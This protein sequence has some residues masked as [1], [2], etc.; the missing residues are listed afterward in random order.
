M[1]LFSKKGHKGIKIHAVP[2]LSSEEID[3]QG[4]NAESRQF[5]NL[6]TKSTASNRGSTELDLMQELQ[7]FIPYTQKAVILKLLALDD[8]EDG[9]GNGKLDSQ[10]IESN[11]DNIVQKI[12]D[13]MINSYANLG[14]LSAL[15][16]ITTY[17]SV[18]SPLSPSEVDF[19]VH[20]FTTYGIRACSV[21]NMASTCCALVTICL[22][23][24]YIYIVSNL[25]ITREDLVWFMIS[26]E[27]VFHCL[28]GTVLCVLL[29][30]SSLLV[31]CF[32]LYSLPTANICVIVGAS[33]L[34]MFF[35]LISP[36]LREVLGRIDKKR[37]EYLSRSGV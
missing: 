32:A 29:A 12:K 24:S 15:V 3:Q 16:G 36:V 28:I 35:V 19:P 9:Q 26:F 13:G 31:S 1:G 11:A 18:L 27:S 37:N 22:A 7:K 17:A 33:I 20:G 6:S 4:N 2:P 21:L 5:D 34:G 25:L 8:G 10:E 30:L 14:V 23:T